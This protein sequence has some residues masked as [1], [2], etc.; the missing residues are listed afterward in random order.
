MSFSGFLYFSEEI[1]GIAEIGKIFPNSYK[2]YFRNLCYYYSMFGMNGS[3]GKFLKFCKNNSINVEPATPQRPANIFTLGYN[4]LHIAEDSVGDLYNAILEG[5]CDF[6]IN[7]VVNDGELIA[8]TFDF[9]TDKNRV[10]FPDSLIC[11]GHMVEVLRNF[12]TKVRHEVDHE[13]EV[14]YF[15]R[16][17]FHWHIYSNLIVVKGSLE[18]AELSKKVSSVW[19]DF[20]KRLP[21]MS[22]RD[23]LADLNAL[24]FTLDMAPFN[25]G[26]LRLPYQ[27][28]AN[29]NAQYNVYKPMRTS[30]TSL[31][32]PEP[33]DVTLYKSMRILNP[34]FYGW[35]KY[36]PAPHVNLTQAQTEPSASGNGNEKQSQWDVLMDS[37]DK[38]ISGVSRGDF[39][40]FNIHDDKVY[41]GH[42][43]FLEDVKS[44]INIRKEGGYI[45]GDDIGNIFVEQFNKYMTIVGSCAAPEV[46][47][48]AKKMADQNDLYGII[49]FNEREVKSYFNPLIIES[50]AQSEDG[51]R[52]KIV[53]NPFKIW[54]GSPLRN[55]THFVFHPS[56]PQFK[57]VE[58]IAF[59]N[60]W[61]GFGEGDGE[62]LTNELNDTE[63]NNLEYII[64]HIRYVLCNDNDETFWYLI[65]WI[66]HLL[67]YPGKKLHTML[68]FQGLEGSGKSLFWNAVMHIIGPH[69][70][71]LPTF[72][73][74]VESGFNGALFSPHLI[75]GVVDDGNYL[76]KQNAKNGAGDVVKNLVTSPILVEQR[77]FKE[78]QNHQNFLNLVILTNY[79]NT[80]GILSD[81]YSR[82]NRLFVTAEINKYNNKHFNRILGILVGPL[83][84]YANDKIMSDFCR[85]ILNNKIL[86]ETENIFE[87]DGSYYPK[88]MMNLVKYANVERMPRLVQFWYD[89]L[90]K[91]E[92]VDLYRHPLVYTNGVKS[93]EQREL[94]DSLR[95]ENP[96]LINCLSVNSSNIVLD[97]TLK[98]NVVIAGDTTTEHVLVSKCNMSRWKTSNRWTSIVPKQLVY[99]N[100]QAWSKQKNF[101]GRTMTFVT[102]WRDSYKL[103]DMR[104]RHKRNFNI[105]LTK[106]QLY[107][108]NVIGKDR[109][110]DSLIPGLNHLMMSDYSALDEQKDI[111]VGYALPF[112][113]L[114]TLDECRE[115]LNAKYN[116][117]GFND[118][119]DVN[120]D[121]Y[122]DFCTNFAD[123][124]C[125][126]RNRFID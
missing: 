80:R 108:I 75:L 22:H 74:M 94:L 11:E 35:I 26:R 37:I 118:S 121:S 20:S 105:R 73:K 9:D 58:G 55:E 87:E 60:W 86:D 27:R 82:R 114:P 7:E 28:S 31:D 24:G 79:S 104:M 39:E 65:H 115:K 29:I 46:I 59:N 15:N 34:D 126:W 99:D 113:C 44:E 8:L 64:T 53:Y 123:S 98:N 96:E 110:N 19:T 48:K 125:K 1:S 88:E 51:K 2:T 47:L 14:S 69:A 91:K 97:R 85:A 56:E 4:Q 50:Y 70:K 63:Y 111:G 25:T 95:V 77:K 90:C 6:A 120:N 81:K 23:G 57:I 71:E 89:V 32:L 101:S 33:L 5:K 106:S 21:V 30:L 116:M 49:H 124:F 52:R 13:F 36:T 12:I 112:T 119:N 78:S 40:Q 18:H 16:D 103:F 102:F 117:E 72:S 76:H 45:K 92:V 42:K 84:G 54:F 93:K 41:P 38:H 68:M 62:P 10:H 66:R 43:K 61:L 83:M 67:K 3:H 122:P 17:S 107:A 100:Y 109:N